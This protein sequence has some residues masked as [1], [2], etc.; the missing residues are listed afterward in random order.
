MTHASSMLL[1]CCALLL[2]MT[3]SAGDRVA[4]ARK[5]RMRAVTA[6]FAKAGVP[7]PPE[8]LY[9]RAFKHERE[10]EVWAGPARGPLAKVKTYPFCAASGELGPKRRQGDLQVPE[11][12]YTLD[13]FN[14]WSSYHLSIRVSYPNAA[15]RH[16]QRAGVPLG[17]DIFVHGD[18][19][20]IGCIA[21]QDAPIEELYLMTLD[22]RAKTKRDTPIHIFPRRL[23][24]QGLAKL[25]ERAGRDADLVAFWRSLQPAYQQF[26]ESRRV[27]RTRVDA[28]TGAYVVSPAQGPRDAR[29]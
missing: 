5:Q 22:T 21:I 20:S 15:D 13:L 7:W 19:V 9:V 2:S 26:E 10:L 18:C 27:P 1:A 4:T 25:E 28:K 17:G 8:Q 3:A 12:F 6:L 16:H 29:R 11:G 24:A 14:P 23:T